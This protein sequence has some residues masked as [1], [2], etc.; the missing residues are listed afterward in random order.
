M[1]KEDAKPPRTWT[2]KAD[3]DIGL[4]RLKEIQQIVESIQRNASTELQAK[5]IIV[6][7]Q[8]IK[9]EDDVTSNYNIFS[10]YFKR[11]ISTFQLAEMLSSLS[12][13]IDDHVIHDSKTE[14][15]VIN[16]PKVLTWDRLLQ[17][18]QSGEPSSHESAHAIFK[19][20]L[21]NC[22][23]KRFVQSLKTD[24]DFAEK[25]FNCHGALFRKF[26][27]KADQKSP[28]GFHEVLKRFSFPC[29]PTRP[30]SSDRGTT[31]TRSSRSYR[32]ASHC[33]LSQSEI[34][35]G[36]LD[37]EKVIHSS[38]NFVKQSL[39]DHV[40][41]KQLNKF[42]TAISTMVEGWMRMLQQC[43]DFGTPAHARRKRRIDTQRNDNKNQS[44][45]LVEQYMFIYALHAF[46]GFFGFQFNSLT[47]GSFLDKDGN[48]VVL[49]EWK[50]YSKT[51]QTSISSTD[52]TKNHIAMLCD[53]G[54]VLSIA[55]EN[56]ADKTIKEDAEAVMDK[57][58]EEKKEQ[59]SKNG[60][61]K[62]SQPPIED[63]SLLVK[64]M[65][66]IHQTQQESK[67]IENIVESITWVK[68]LFEPGSQ[69]N[70]M[71]VITV[72]HGVVQLVSGMILGKKRLGIFA[73]I[74]GISFVEL[75]IE[76]VMHDD[77]VEHG[78]TEKGVIKVSEFFSFDTPGILDKLLRFLNYASTEKKYD[79]PDDDSMKWA[80][81]VRKKGK[82]RK[83]SAV[84]KS[85]VDNRSNEDGSGGGPSGGG[86]DQKGGDSSKEHDDSQGDGSDDKM[87]SSGQER[88][89]GG[90]SSHDV[91][92][93]NKSCSNDVSTSSRSTNQFLTSED[94]KDNS[95]DT[96]E[97]RRQSPGRKRDTAEVSNRTAE[98]PPSALRN[99]KIKLR[100]CDMTD[101]E[102]DVFQEMIMGKSD[103]I[104]LLSQIKPQEV[105]GHGRCGNVT[106]VKYQGQL[107]A[108][109]EFVLDDD[110]ERDPF[111]VYE[112]EL[113]IMQELQGYVPKLHFRCPWPL[114][115]TIGMELGEPMPD[116]F[117]K[118][119]DEQLEELDLLKE[120]VRKRGYVQGDDK[121]RN[122]IRLTGRKDT[123]PQI[124]MIDFEMFEKVEVTND[125]S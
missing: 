107:C 124:V 100:N 29:I 15:T 10:S 92:K 119:S 53:Y 95:L 110:D 17:A 14:I 1:S 16:V 66:K 49:V 39:K 79:L 72:F 8:S 42:E 111:E 88:G 27:L 75:A 125:K 4:D 103:D 61:K 45:E 99:N 69:I 73:S 86:N 58:L 71:D 57:V 55:N 112:K 41:D 81:C 90:T 18:V 67:E 83:L 38:K 46:F 56:Y 30:S 35:F 82:S 37:L 7:L 97:D 65:L 3:D 62:S 109:K 59:K 87:F 47:D 28:G 120:D 11:P 93:H 105:L 116:D 94:C 50:Q 23:R 101:E 102:Q 9:S 32:N 74:A 19:I 44:G 12:D 108:M 33:C 84:H 123:K 89:S 70:S 20:F 98:S 54:N 104:P 48:L 64:A 25:Y 76:P 36:S 68:S 85:P 63:P 5:P 26:R 21:D 2:F 31:Q 115:P 96:T 40:F 13:F 80:E 91:S 34:R 77:I 51:V 52:M 43:V 22:M 114:R 122:Y 106:K 117:D 78:R 121:G 6:Y 24:E 118:W 113:K 60:A